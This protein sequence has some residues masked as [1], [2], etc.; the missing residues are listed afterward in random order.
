MAVAL[1]RLPVLW[2]ALAGLSVLACQFFTP[3]RP[4][5]AP[6]PPTHTPHP[7]ASPVP[8]GHFSVD[9]A[10]LSFLAPAP[11]AGGVKLD[12]NRFPFLLLFPAL[13][14]APAPAWLAAATRVTYRVESAT[15]PQVRDQPGASGAGYVQY[16]IVALE[17]DVAVAT[18]KLY[19]DTADGVLPSLSFPVLGHPGV[20]EFWLNPDVLANAEQAATDGLSV[21]PL[22]K[23]TGAGTFHT[24]RFQYTHANAQYVWMFDVDSGLL[25]FFSWS[26]GSDADP[27]RQLGQLT[28]AARRQLALPWQAGRLP[29]WV[30]RARRLRYSGTYATTVA[31]AATVSLP[32]SA[33]VNIQSTFERWNAYSLSTVIQGQASSVVEALTGGDQAFD[34]LWLS[35]EALAALADGQTLDTDPV[36]G[37][38]LTVARDPD[39]ISLTETGQHY[40]TR[41]VYAS[42]DGRLLELIQQQQN[43]L[44]NIVTDLKLDNAP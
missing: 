21:T 5:P 14:D 16:D 32:A 36:T 44:A 19:L 18:S 8:A 17:P 7:Q 30:A 1:R 10:A 37:A 23:D 38:V 33:T 40:A 13:R 28:L 3:A 26:I 11:P 31:G 29:D 41:L 2:L 27:N 34:G 20:G 6:P 39:T 24:V 35:P 15:I 25:V 9:A 43:G 4:T 42:D 22:D 12:D